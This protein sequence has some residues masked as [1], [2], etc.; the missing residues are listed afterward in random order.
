MRI[1]PELQIQWVHEVESDHAVI[2]ML[3]SPR[4]N[5]RRYKLQTPLTVQRSSDSGVCTTY[6][7]KL[8]FELRIPSSSIA[9]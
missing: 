7:Q 4:L 6:E 8:L 1:Y 2:L 3:F 9:D 5:G